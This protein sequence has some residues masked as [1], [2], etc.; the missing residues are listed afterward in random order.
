MIGV[1]EHTSLQFDSGSATAS[2]LGRGKATFVFGDSTTYLE[3]GETTSI[4]DL[5]DTEPRSVSLAPMDHLVSFD[6]ALREGDAARA[7]DI[8][9]DQEPGPEQYAMIVR[10]GNAASEGL[11]DRAELI[12][13]LVDA[14][15]ALRDAARVAQRWD[16]GDT[17][18]DAL[19]AYGV[20]VA[21]GPDGT[22]WALSEPREHP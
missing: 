3:A 15:L 17:I 22:T 16:E 21:D 19:A 18:R 6:D 13:P 8:I 9:L 12:R 7:T 4:G 1:D 14:L 5:L 11:T 2:V 20:V 10:L